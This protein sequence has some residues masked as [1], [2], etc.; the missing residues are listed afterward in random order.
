ML[1]LAI[2]AVLIVTLVFPLVF[3]AW[4]IW[5]EGRKTQNSPTDRDPE[6]GTTHVRS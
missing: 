2:V 6:S 5:R 3:Q 4:V 1:T